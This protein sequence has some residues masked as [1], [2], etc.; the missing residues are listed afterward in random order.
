[1]LWRRLQN[2]APH[3]PANAGSHFAPYQQVRRTVGSPVPDSVSA[4]GS[5]RDSSV[6]QSTAGRRGQRTLPQNDRCGTHPHTR[7]HSE[8]GASRD[9]WR[10]HTLAPTEESRSTLARERRIV[11]RSGPAGAADGPEH[12]ADSGAADGSERDSSVA[13]RSAWRKSRRTLP[14]N[15]RCGTHPHTRCHSEGGASRGSSAHPNSGAD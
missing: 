5:E 4:D 15:D 7:C 13:L 10:T 12:G 11:S 9:P 14:Q 8:G 3:L 6:A 1:M 2:P